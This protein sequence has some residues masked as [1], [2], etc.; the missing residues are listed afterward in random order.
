[1]W[2]F[3]YIGLKNKIKL[4]F[5]P[6]TANKLHYLL[7]VWLICYIIK[8]TLTPNVIVRYLFQPFCH[9]NV[10]Y[11]RKTKSAAQGSYQNLNSMKPVLFSC[12]LWEI[13][14]QVNDKR[15]YWTPKYLLRASFNMPFPVCTMILLILWWAWFKITPII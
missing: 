3:S 15:E 4:K 8:L 9:Q 11:P 6:V 10:C 14:L 1:M 2:Y 13:R 7:K 12:Y 5:T